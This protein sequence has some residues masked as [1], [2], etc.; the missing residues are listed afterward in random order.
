MTTILIFVSIIVAGLF[1]IRMNKQETDVTKTKTKVGIMYVSSIAKNDLVE[2]VEEKIRQIN[3][4]KNRLLNTLKT[5]L[6]DL[7]SSYK[8]CLE[9]NNEI[10]SL[11]E[12]LLSYYNI[13]Q[14][15]L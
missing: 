10:I 15:C 4:E 12:K 11:L 14:V 2:L 9:R 6:D 7:Q 13:F 8:N 1:L 3:E 5:E